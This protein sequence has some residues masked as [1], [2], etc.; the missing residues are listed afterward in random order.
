MRI[1]LVSPGAKIL[2]TPRE[3]E[4]L[5]GMC[6][7]YATCGEDFENTVGM[8]AHA[9]GRTSDDVIASLTEMKGRYHADPEYVR[10]RKKLPAE[11]P[12]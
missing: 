5:N 7:C 12:L 3:R 11:F 4:L 10:L 9:R 6:N 2:M 8:V 1:F